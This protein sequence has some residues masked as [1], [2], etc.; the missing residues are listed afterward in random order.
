MGPGPALCPAT[1]LPG[2]DTLSFVISTEA[3]PDF[4]RSR[5]LATTTYAAFRRERRT[6]FASASKFYRKS[7]GAERRDLCV[8]DLSWKCFSRESAR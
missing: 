7:G 1:T 2:S 6:K 5:A 8:D 3:Y 4:L